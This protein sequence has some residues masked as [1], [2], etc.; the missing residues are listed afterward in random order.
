[1]PTNVRVIHARDF[2]RATPAG[3]L[4]L[5]AS[6]TLLTAIMDASQSLRNVEVLIDTRKSMAVLNTTDLFS[7]AQKAA[8]CGGGLV[9]KTAVLCPADRFDH[10]RFFALCAERHGVEIGAFL[11][12]ESAMEWLI[13][14]DQTR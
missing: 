13:G 14:E 11:D 4:D 12:Y 1:M 5:P 8:D 9:H 6:E 7:L 10:A 2:I 3:V